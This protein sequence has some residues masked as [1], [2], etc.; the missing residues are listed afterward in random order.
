MFY[1]RL[2]LTYNG[3]NKM[4]QIDYGKY[5]NKSHYWLQYV[6]SRDDKEIKL[7]LQ[8]ANGAKKLWK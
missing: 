4:V 1:K 8:N 5:S 7:N 6:L 2:L 3:Y